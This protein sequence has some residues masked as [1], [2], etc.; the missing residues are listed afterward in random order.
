MPAA[1]RRQVDQ[2]RDP[3]GAATDEVGAAG[4][5]PDGVVAV[6]EQPPGGVEVAGRW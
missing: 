3:G 6:R 1:R 4:E 5:Q 2:R